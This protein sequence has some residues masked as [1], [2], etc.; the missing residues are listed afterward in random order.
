MIYTFYSYKGG[1][2]RSMA[3][4]NVA[5]CFYLQGLKVVMIDWDLEAPGLESFFFDP[6]PDD[7]SNGN[8]PATTGKP[9]ALEGIAMVQ[10]K[11]GLID[12]LTEYKR[13]YS[14][15]LPQQG[16]TSSLEV[17][18]AFQQLFSEETAKLAGGA[19]EFTAVLDQHMPPLSTYLVPIHAGSAKVESA[20]PTTGSLSLL[21][22]GWRYKERFQAYGQAVQAFDWDGFYGTYRGKDYFNWMQKKLLEVADVILID[23]R[24]GVTEMGGVC[25]RQMADV[26]VSFSAPN[27]QN[28]DGVARMIQSFK[29]KE[30]IKARD[31]R[32]LDT[33]I[34][35]TRVDPAELD[36]L[37]KFQVRF[38][39]LADEKTNAPEQFKDL[40]RTFWELQIPYRAKYSYQER[41]VVGP[42]VTSVDP[43]KGLENAY[44]K[45]ASHLALLA[46]ETHALRQRFAARLQREFPSRLPKVVLSYMTDAVEAA[47]AIQ[48]FLRSA[49]IQLW[50]DLSHE[51]ESDDLQSSTSIISQ[52]TH[53]VVVLSERAQADSG[54]IRRELRFAR[55]QGKITHVLLT[56]GQRLTSAWLQSAESHTKPEDLV[57]SLRTTPRTLR[58]P[59]L[60]PTVAPGYVERRAV[61]QE[62]KADLMEAAKSTGRPVMAVWGQGGSGKTALMTSLCHDEDIIDAYP[63][64]IFFVNASEAAAPIRIVTAISPETSVLDASVALSTA[65]S[66][67]RGRRCLLVI[68]DVWTDKEITPLMTL[69]E[70]CAIV[71]LTRDSTLRLL[72][73]A[74]W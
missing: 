9:Q 35:P 32:G 21:P 16:A 59:V 58:A 15:I 37:T 54:I 68:D 20:S 61:Q 48:S 55:Q 31:N 25:A 8:E 11:L 3:L 53:L 29:R 50:P 4:A 63:G 23:S 28:I 30:T 19:D 40:K 51:S 70:P 47:A 52:T 13:S 1:V 45:L 49:G 6:G 27:N 34:V 44:W 71:L 10:S 60:A 73:P 24:T 12:M 5:E 36:D 66:L 18:K 65:T 26:V 57:Q 22:V 43:T 62:L 39:R 69:A 17:P 41:R 14:S 2:G 72:S 42:D 56:P 33:I 67:L 7:A 74:R 46:P 38:E 64:G